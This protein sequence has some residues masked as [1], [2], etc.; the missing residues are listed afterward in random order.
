MPGVPAGGA[1]WG[2][3]AAALGC[4]EAVARQEIRDLADGQH[5]LYLAYEGKIG[6]SET[7]HDAAMARA[8]EPEAD[9]LEASREEARTRWSAY[10]DC[11]EAGH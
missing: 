4:D 3:V 5:D 10:L 7:D 11:T 6:M 9:G 8:A 1:S 2:Q